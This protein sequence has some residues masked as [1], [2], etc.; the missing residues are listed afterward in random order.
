MGRWGGRDSPHKTE[1]FRE[2]ME[3]ARNPSW[4]TPE[5]SKKYREAMMSIK[6]PP[7]KQHHKNFPFFKEKEKEKG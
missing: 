2:K 1:E 4:P 7:T 6:A 5:E 3:K